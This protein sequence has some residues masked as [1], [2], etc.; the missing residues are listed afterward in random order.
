VEELTLGH[1]ASIDF[2]IS[3]D[4]LCV[5]P[6]CYPLRDVGFHLEHSNYSRWSMLSYSHI[7]VRSLKFVSDFA[8]KHLSFDWAESFDKLDKALSFIPFICLE[9]TS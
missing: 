1:P 2:H 5:G 9:Y 7:I 3:F 4:W 6:L 8:H